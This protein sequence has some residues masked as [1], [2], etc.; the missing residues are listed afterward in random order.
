MKKNLLMLSFLAGSIAAW[1]QNHSSLQP[2]SSSLLKAKPALHDGVPVKTFN[3]TDTIRYP[4]V[5]Q[6]VLGNPANFYSFSIWQSDNEAISQT[7]VLSGST[8]SIKGVEFFG[9]NGYDPANLVGTASLTV[10]ASIYSVDANNIPVTSLGSGTVTFTSTTAAYHYVTFATP[11]TVTGNYAVVIDVTNANGVYTSLINDSAP[12]QSYDELLTRFKSSYYTTSA[13]TFVTIPTLTASGFTGGPYNFEPLV[14]P[15]VAYTL[16]TTATATPN[17]SCLG[18]AVTFTGASTP[19]G[20]LNNRMY[21]YQIFRTHFG[22]APSDSTFV[23]DMGTPLVWSASHA[24]TYPTAGAHT[25]DFYTLGGFWNSCVDMASVAI[26]VNPLPVVTAGADVSVCPGTPATLTAGGANAYSWDNGGGTNA[27]ATVTPSATTTYT[28]TG[29]DGNGCQNT[30]QVVVTV[31][32]LDNAGFTYASNTICEGSANVTPT[33]A[34]TGTFTSTP[35]GLVFAN[36]T[37]GEIDVN[38]STAGTYS[39]THSVNAVCAN[40]NTQSITITSAP[41]AGFS[42]AS[43]SYCAGSANPAPTFDPG[44]S[45]GTFSSTTGLSINNAT[46]EINIPASTAGTYTVTN[47][48]AASGSCP[49][50]SSTTTVAIYAQPTA[51]VTGGGSICGTGTATVTITL[52]GEAPYDFTYTN[53][54]TPTTVTGHTSG[55]YTITASAA[56]TYTVTSVSDANCSNTGTGSALVSVFANPTV[57][58]ASLPTVC[59]NASAI[60]LTQGLPAGGTYSGTGISGATFTP[61]APGSVTVTYAYTDA[62]GC[63]ASATGTISVEAAPTVAMTALADVCSYVAAFPLTGGTPAGG[64]YSGPGVTAGS[65]NPA[66]AGVGTHTIVYTYANTTGAM[67]SS[68]ASKTI[69]VKNC[70]GIEENEL[71]TSFV[72]YPNPAHES[73]IV[74]FETTQSL[75]AEINMISLDGKMVYTNKVPQTNNFSQEISVVGFPAGVYLIQVHTANGSAMRRLVVQ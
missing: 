16:N 73:V 4:Q 46:G 19:T 38:A 1:G 52:T 56:G 60:T 51:A 29:T 66:T 41:E 54:T 13:N 18:T 65:F 75:S 42:Y 57:S 59:S 61:S 25:A 45:A 24:Y 50:S 69:V 70:A 17:P 8:L 20:V 2:A 14:A 49:A 22:T 10:R 67:C 11:I 39:V 63:S 37:T 23:W 12:N 33:A 47:S 3:C 15:I 71:E 6:Q 9:K 44:S 74:A 40:T 53:G 30:D 35:A 26:T 21:N 58:L 28:V 64:T 5:K 62:N 43:A 34:L 27:T 32:P 68:T 7:F 72:V 31:T 36:A 55:T 48:I